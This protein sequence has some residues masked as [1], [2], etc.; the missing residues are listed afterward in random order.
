MLRV[1]TDWARMLRIHAGWIRRM[2]RVMADWHWH[3]L[4]AKDGRAQ[5]HVVGQGQ[6]GPAYGPGLSGLVPAHVM[7]QGRA[8]LILKASA[9]WAHHMLRVTAGSAGHMLQVEASWA[10]HISRV[11]ADWACHMLRGKAR[12]ARHMITG[13]AWSDRHML[14]VKAGYVAGPGIWFGPR[15]AQPV[16]SYESRPALSGS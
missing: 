7:G 6:L 4:P 5:A 2:L 14:Q 15:L 10:P 8:R 12:W 3:T 11:M 9:S 1:K 16:T 13:K